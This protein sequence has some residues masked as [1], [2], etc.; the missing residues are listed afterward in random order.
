M[1]LISVLDPSR[2]ILYALTHIFQYIASL[3]QGHT[4]WKFCVI[5]RW[6][7]NWLLSTSENV[8]WNC[9]KWGFLIWTK[10]WHLIFDFQGTTKVLT[11][12]W[13]WLTNQILSLEY[14]STYSLILQCHGNNSSRKGSWRNNS[15]WSEDDWNWLKLATT[16]KIN[17]FKRDLGR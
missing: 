4:M 12:Q 6:Y 14:I 10:L 16:E 8:I 17:H 7:F 5:Q 9:K 3:T 2:L 13:P 1:W 15:P 11:F